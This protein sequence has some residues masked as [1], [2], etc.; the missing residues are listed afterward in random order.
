MIDWGQVDS[1]RADLG[2]GFHE[3]VEVFLA[4]VDEATGRIDAASP[5]EQ[6]AADLHFLKGAALN[7]GFSAFAGLCAEGEVQA[8]AGGAVD[9]GPILACFTASREEFVEGLGQRRGA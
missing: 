2:D 1:L 4:E 7:L 5:P 9:T 8:N 3:L 6:M